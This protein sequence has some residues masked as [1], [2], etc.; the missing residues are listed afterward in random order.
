MPLRS[1]KIDNG[2]GVILLHIYQRWLQYLYNQFSCP[3]PHQ[4]S[5]SLGW[6]EDSS[7]FSAH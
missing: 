6:I 4:P 7:G 1:V 5:R 3:I 2:G